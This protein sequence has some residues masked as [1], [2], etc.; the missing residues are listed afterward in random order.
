MSGLM[1]T[2]RLISVHPHPE[3]DYPRVIIPCLGGGQ[4]AMPADQ[5]IG[6]FVDREIARNW[7][8]VE[9]MTARDSTGQRACY[10]LYIPPH[11]KDALMRAL[12]SGAM[13]DLEQFGDVIASNYGSAPS[14]E[15]RQLIKNRFGIN[16]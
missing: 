9:Q 3:F 4:A 11:R 7:H 1:Q 6:S 12:D 2:A 8:R 15:T 14:P 5:P 10:F 13:I 16:V